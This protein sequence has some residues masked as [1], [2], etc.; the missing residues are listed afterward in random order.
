MRS[1]SGECIKAYGS[2][3]PR[4][5]NKPTAAEDKKTYD[6]RLTRGELGDLVKSLSSFARV[7]R[8]DSAIR[9]RDKFIAALGSEPNENHVV[10]NK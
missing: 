2:A 10:K 3:W 1:S 6:V 7:T 5:R 8:R 4:I 9:L